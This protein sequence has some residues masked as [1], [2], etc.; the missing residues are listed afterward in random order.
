MPCLPIH[1]HVRCVPVF[2]RVKSE[3][4]VTTRSIEWPIRLVDTPRPNHVLG[5][6][7][8]IPSITNIYARL[9]RT[10]PCS[11]CAR[12]SRGEGQ[13][14]SHILDTNQRH[15]IPTF[16]A[17]TIDL[18]VHRRCPTGCY[19][20]RYLLHGSPRIS[21]GIHGGQLKSMN[22]HEDPWKSW[23]ILGDP[24]KSMEILEYPGRSMEIHGESWSIQD[25]F[26]WRL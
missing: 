3:F 19:T 21:M 10:L 1:V 23:N 5:G 8:R 20:Q 14:G 26:R 6:A 22:I 13:S 17:R 2:L 4:R 11:L 24:W 15:C 18:T 12:I 25:L 9:G 16:V 7:S